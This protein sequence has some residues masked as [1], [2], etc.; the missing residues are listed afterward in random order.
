MLYEVITLVVPD[1]FVA[2]AVEID[3]ELKIGRRHE[4][5]LAHGT[6]PGTGHP[7]P[8]YVPMVENGQCLEELLTKIFAPPVIIS[9]GGQRPYHRNFSYNFV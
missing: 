2:V 7:L 6:G 8:G 5:H 1:I 3:G 9:E 4:L